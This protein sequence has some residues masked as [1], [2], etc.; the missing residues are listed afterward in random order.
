MGRKVLHLD[1]STV[2]DQSR[3]EPLWALLTKAIAEGV[4]TGDQDVMAAYHLAES[5]A[6]APSAVLRQG[7]NVQGVNWSGTAMPAGVDW[8]TVR[9]MT[10]GPNGSTIGS[11]R[12]AWTG[13]HKPMPVLNVVEIDGAGRIVL[14]LPG[15][16]PLPV[17]EN[18][19]LALLERDPGLRTL[20]LKHPVLFL[21]TGPGTLSP[22]L[23][24]RFSE[25]TG[26]PAYRYSA[27][28][29]LSSGDPATPLGIL[30]LTDPAT[31]APGAW[32][33]SA[34]QANAPPPPPARAT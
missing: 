16:A 1:A 26:R 25:N 18:E 30:A 34:R 28:M 31:R 12:P 21:T 33:R 2:W 17:S 20:P 32:T 15:R 14:H 27:P 23:V 7:A 3:Q 22:G 11:V 29:M 6:F 13:P 5:G 24:R 10:F 4:D 19:F 9:Q 8:G